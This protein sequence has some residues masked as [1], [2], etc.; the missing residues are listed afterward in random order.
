MKRLCSFFLVL[1]LVAAMAS[2]PALAADT[3]FVYDRA[4]ILSDMELD[5]L[6]NAAEGISRTYDVGVYIVTLPDMRDYGYTDIEACAEAF[7]DEMGLGLGSDRTGIM[8]ILSMAE[9]DYD[10]DAHGDFAHYAFTDYGKTTISDA[11]LDNFRRDDWYGGFYDYLARCEEMLAL[12]QS[13]TPVDITAADRVSGRITPGGLLA[14]AVLSLLIAWLICGW[15]KGKMQTAK[16]A[17]DA[18]SYVLGGTAQITHRQ[19][20]FTHTTQMR[21]KIE[22]S[23]N[24]RGGGGGGGTTV[25]SGGHSHSS[26]KF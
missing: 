6:T 4:D 17:A 1:L 10:I 12:A 15:L 9:R 8:L 26:G 20:R 2:V 19:D 24:S 18:D 21:R 14:S 7:F 16:L 25:S 11:F 3:E 22:R 23:D 13:G 5:V